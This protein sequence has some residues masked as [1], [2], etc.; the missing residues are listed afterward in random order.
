MTLHLKPG[1]SREINDRVNVN[2]GDTA[3]SMPSVAERMA[4]DDTVRMMTSDDSDD[5]MA[6]VSR[7]A[8]LMV[9]GSIA[10]D[11]VT[12]EELT[13]ALQFAGIHH[14]FWTELIRYLFFQDL[15]RLRGPSRGTGPT[16]PGV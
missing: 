14:K 9:K 10:E 6:Q 5:R 1:T 16:T 3:P 15:I 13:E 7:A 8:Y 4:S 11:L 2:I 12:R